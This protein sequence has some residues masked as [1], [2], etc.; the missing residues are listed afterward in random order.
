MAEQ[1]ILL[2]EDEEAIAEFLVISLEADGYAVDHAATVSEA[3]R[4]L[5]AQRYALVVTDWRLPDGD[6]VAVADKAADLGAKTAVF[7]GYALALAPE[8]AAR[9]QVWMKP[10]RPGE[11][12]AAVKR[13]IGRAS[14]QSS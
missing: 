7:T 8:R 10:M 3:E 9:H 12:L 5:T 13:S 1:R 11:F 2:L 6:G 14:A 4:L